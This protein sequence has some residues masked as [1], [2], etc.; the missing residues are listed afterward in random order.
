M[1]VCMIS[2]DAV[3]QPDA[4]RLFALPAL[5]ALRRRGLFCQ[6][7]ETIYPTLTSISKRSELWL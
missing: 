4:D 3:A 2:L 6:N 1:R 5:L 7:V